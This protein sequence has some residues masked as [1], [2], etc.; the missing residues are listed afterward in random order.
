M[1]EAARNFPHSLASYLFEVAKKFNAFM[2]TI[3]C[4]GCARV[5]KTG[6]GKD[7]G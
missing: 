5:T 4:W 3:K 1:E 6:I 7:S 2:T